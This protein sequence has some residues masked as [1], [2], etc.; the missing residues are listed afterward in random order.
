MKYILRFIDKHFYLITAILAAVGFIGGMVYAHY[1]CD[2]L[3]KQHKAAVAAGVFEQKAVVETVAVDE[4]TI[5]TMPLYNVPLD[6]DLQYYIID[7]SQAH[8]IDPAIIFAMCYRESTYNANCIG[9]NCNS[10]G[11]MQIQPKWHGERMERLNCT[12]LLDPY[13]NITVGLDYL[14]EL[15]SRYDGDMEKALVAYNQGSFKGTVTQYAKDVMEKAGE[16]TA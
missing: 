15:L 3:E 4:P 1:A 13:D 12:D 14:C 10:Y 16:L 8:G 7:Q 9:D 5:K 2:S 6:D 11:L